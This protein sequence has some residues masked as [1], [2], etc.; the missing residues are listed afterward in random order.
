[1]SIESWR[2]VFVR[3]SLNAA[4]SYDC[5]FGFGLRDTAFGLAARVRVTG[6]RARVSIKLSLCYVF[7]NYVTKVCVY[8]TKCAKVM[9]LGL[10]Y[11]IQDSG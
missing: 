11:G 6:Y 4:A 10:D 7:R 9:G 8:V 3:I 1:M 5:G 2:Q